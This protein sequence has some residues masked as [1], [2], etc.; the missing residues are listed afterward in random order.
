MKQVIRLI[1][2]CF[3]VA[4]SVQSQPVQIP[5]FEG[6][7][8]RTVAQRLKPT[9][10]TICNNFSLSRGGD[11]TLKVRPGF[12]SAGYRANQ[13]SLIG[14]VSI[15][16]DDETRRLIFSA[17]STGIGW[18]YN[19]ACSI[20]TNKI[21][22]ATR[23][24]TP[25]SINSPPSAVT[26]LGTTYIVNGSAYGNS[27]PDKRPDL[28]HPFPLQPPGSP[29]VTPVKE[30]GAVSGTVRYALIYRKT[31]FVEGDTLVTLAGDAVGARPYFGV[32]TRAV[33]VSNAKVLLSN[34]EL[35]TTQQ[36]GPTT[37]RDTVRYILLRT[38]GL[39]DQFD[40]RRDSIYYIVDTLRLDSSNYLTFQYTDTASDATIRA[41][42]Q[43]SLANQKDL[44]GTAGVFLDGT[45]TADFFMALGA[46][47]WT[48]NGGVTNSGIWQ[49]A[50]LKMNGSSS[51]G[52]FSWVCTYVD[53]ANGN[54]SDTG[55]SFMLR[56]ST[57]TGLVDLTEQMIFQLPRPPRNGMRV[58]IY[59][60]PI[61]RVQIDSSLRKREVKE[62]DLL[63]LNPNLRTMKAFNPDQYRELISKLLKKTN[64]RNYL[65]DTL[66]AYRYY[67]LA[68]K[69]GNTQ[70]VDSLPYDSLIQRDRLQVPFFPQEPRK[71]VASGNRIYMLSSDPTGDKIWISLP[72]TVYAKD[73]LSFQNFKTLTGT[74][75]I[76]AWANRF[77][78]AIKKNVEGGQKYDFDTKVEP[79]QSYGSISSRGHVKVEGL[80]DVY[81]SRT[82]IVLD[83]ES[84]TLERQF[85]S[86]SLS[87]KL[88]NFRA[89]SPT[90]LSK[91]VAG[92]SPVT[93]EVLFSVGDTIYCFD[94]RTG[95]CVTYTG[96]TFSSAAIFG[97]DSSRSGIPSDTMYF[98]M[99]GQ[100]KIYR[101]GFS[102]TD[103]GAAIPVTYQTGALLE[104]TP[105]QKQ[106]E[107]VMLR[108][109]SGDTDT[110]S[111]AVRDES[112]AQDTVKSFALSSAKYRNLGF[113]FNDFSY[114]FLRFSSTATLESTTITGFDIHWSFSTGVPE[115]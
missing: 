18:G 49:G 48:S 91:A 58:R 16:N 107:R 2:F 41:N 24:R 61:E 60:A 115:E 34:F 42:G 97:V 44:Y 66:V 74:R 81:L 96:F 51:I 112:F 39:T 75:V 104:E 46:P 85:N 28:S 27:F 15:T 40:P 93:Q 63:D 33:T 68:E 69:E 13:D 73:L 110:C 8:T 22:T 82:D 72:D 36:L 6:L 20:N 7:N 103:K 9:E 70:Y 30:A 77:G 113:G 76:D 5:A 1:L 23:M 109:N 32:F 53:T 12:D 56:I 31:G 59:R 3:T 99:P 25:V 10:A 14:L 21:S 101:Y 47:M 43:Y 108:V 57:D 105:G 92:Y 52:G 54:E 88:S 26:H 106:L 80:G 65:S 17:D 87:E 100:S 19:Y 4:A 84:Q 114:G 55:A 64:Q 95:G 86:G 79:T 35:P 11:F 37:T 71:I 94:R 89:L 38:L 45:A 111:F 102:T 29:L 98:T 62:S 90:V 50:G 78:I 67:L 83:A